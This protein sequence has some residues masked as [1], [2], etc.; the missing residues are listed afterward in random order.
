[1]ID[2]PVHPLTEALIERS[3]AHAPQ[4]MLLSGERGVGLEQIARAIAEKNLLTVVE[5][6]DVNGVP[7]RAGTIAIETIRGLYDRTKVKQTKPVFVIIADAD[8]MSHGAQNAFLKLL[9]EPVSY[10]HFLLTST[11]AQHL[12]PT[13]ISRVQQHTIRPIDSQQTQAL[14]SELTNDSKKQAQLQF[15]AQGLPSEL[16]RL[17]HDE[18]YFATR[19]SDM[20]RARTFLQGTSYE[21][22]SLIQALK[23][24]REAAQQ[25]MSDCVRI[26][27]HTLQRSAS[28][29]AIRQLEDC[30]AASENIAKNYHVGLQLTRFVL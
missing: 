20:A 29:D 30:V 16:L 3:R 22:I 23:T 13:I 9:E 12:I 15:I 28:S 25:L 21:K 26:L 11:A 1:M 10:V 17:A 5:P 2:F 8:R 24:D 4:A 6:S 27:R 7:S 14:I 18:T 19:A